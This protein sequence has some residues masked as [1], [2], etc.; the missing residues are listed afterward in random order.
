MHQIIFL[1]FCGGTCFQGTHLS[2]EGVRKI[3]PSVTLDGMS[4]LLLFHKKIQGNLEGE[5]GS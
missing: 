5:T 3:K 4:I 2:I 1:K